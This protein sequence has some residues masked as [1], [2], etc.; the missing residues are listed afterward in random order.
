MLNNNPRITTH[1]DVWKCTDCWIRI[2]KTVMMLVIVTPSAVDLLN[3]IENQP[4]IFPNTFLNYCLTYKRLF[5]HI[6]YY[7]C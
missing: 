6:N 1:K 2:I 3:I 5:R 7:N 4:F